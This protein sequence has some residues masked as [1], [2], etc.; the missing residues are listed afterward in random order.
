MPQHA[1]ELIKASFQQTGQDF[2]QPFTHCL[3]LA[4]QAPP[5]APGGFYDPAWPEHAVL[6]ANSS[7]IRP[8]SRHTGFNSR[9]YH[10]RKRPKFG[11]SLTGK[12][13][14]LT[15]DNTEPCCA[16]QVD[17]FTPP[18]HCMLVPSTVVSIQ[19]MIPF[20]AHCACRF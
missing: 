1:K 13:C 6:E 8:A 5:A 17:C 14:L 9:S 11:D 19:H 20:V 16:L 7:L 4:Q 2:R 3:E 15:T 10:K 18:M 12:K